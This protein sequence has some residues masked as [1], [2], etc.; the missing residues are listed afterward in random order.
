MEGGAGAEPLGDARQ[1]S[2]WRQM[3]TDPSSGSMSE[4][5]GSCEGG[6]RRTPSPRIP[7]AHD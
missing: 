2:W 1:L 4:T 6:I 3:R 5:G 7:S